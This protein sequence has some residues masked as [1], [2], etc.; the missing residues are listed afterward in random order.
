MPLTVGFGP[1]DIAVSIGQAEIMK[2]V[3]QR[4]RSGLA[5][6]FALVVSGCAAVSPDMGDMT[7]AYSDA[8]ERHEMN[9][10]LRNLLRASDGLPMRF[11]A[12]PTVVGTGILESNVGLSGKVLGGFLDNAS[13]S[14]SLKSSRGFN[15]SLASLDNERF[16]S[17]F[18]GE[19]SLETIN[20][21]ALSNMERQV[22]FTLVLQSATMTDNNVSLKPVEN[23]ATTPAA[24]LRFQ[25]TLSDLVASGLRTETFNRL[26]TIG[27]DLSR[28]EW[29]NRYLTSRLADDSAVRTLEI[30]TPAGPRYRILRR[31]RTVRFCLSPQDY[32]KRTGSRVNQWLECRMPGSDLRTEAMRPS[33]DSDASTG[34]HVNIRSTRDVYKFVGQIV[35]AQLGPQPWIPTVQ[36]QGQGTGIA[37]GEYPLIVVRK[38]EPGPGEKALAI[39][40]HKG[41]TYFVPSSNAGLSSQVFES[42]SLLLSASMVKDA[43]PAS[44]GILVR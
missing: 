13:S 42:L 37:P 19:L 41:E 36:V 20:V 38:G 16:T 8:I 12:V 27:S 43:I 5:C 44:P 2:T 32:L 39:A 18:V 40:Q 28:D 30:E 23:D 35:K 4:F 15:F 31:E 3:T 24:Y 17:A 29:L 10:I 7:R 22:L 26:T 11:Q 25:A 6:V 34:L 9:Q 1:D 33:Q 14:P 21:F